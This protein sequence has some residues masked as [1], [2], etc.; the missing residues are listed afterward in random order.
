MASKTTID[1]SALSKPKPSTSAPIS[2]LPTDIARLYTYAHP[3]IILSLYAFQFKSIVADPVPAL[4]NI[5]APLAV[6]QVA[7]VAIC[8]PPTGETPKV[9]KVKPGEKKAAKEVGGARGSVVPAFLSLLLTALAATPLLTATLIL[10]G[11]P[12]TTHHF[13]TLLCGAHVA[14]LSTL[15]LVYVHG[16]NGETWRQIVA[17]LVPMDEVYGGLIG[18]VLGA[19]LGAVP[20]PLDWDREWQKW[21]VTIVTGAYLGYALGKV[22]GGTVF[23][24]KKIMFA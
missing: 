20:I 8:L 16:V 2:P 23:K 22:L 24:G 18:T 19:W 1:A 17:L 13:H 7:Y 14:L 6:L 3:A 5:L 9:K 10:F 15:P 11:A 4:L 21:P 12:V